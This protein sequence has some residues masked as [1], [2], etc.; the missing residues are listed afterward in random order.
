MAVSQKIG[1]D[2]NPTFFGDVSCSYAKKASAGP[3]SLQTC[4]HAQHMSILNWRAVFYKR[5]PL[6]PILE[7][8]Y[9]TKLLTP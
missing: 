1:F 7:G 2:S 5:S 9:F 3:N 6:E 4:K 8:Y